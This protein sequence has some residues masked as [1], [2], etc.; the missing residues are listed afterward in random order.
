MNYSPIQNADFSTYSERVKD[1][2]HQSEIAVIDINKIYTFL[3]FISDRMN[4]EKSFCHGDFT[5]DNLIITQNSICLIDPNPIEYSSWLLDISKL[6][7]SFR[8]FGYLDDLKYVYSRYDD[9]RSLITLLELTH[10]VRILKYIRHSD[11]QL[12]T[13]A[14]NIIEELLEQC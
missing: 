5:V 7:H 3:Y 11:V 4:V 14:L 12:Y 2:L 13:K 10:W 8:R 1:H 6:A 9:D